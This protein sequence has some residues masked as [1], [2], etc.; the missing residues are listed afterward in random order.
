MQKGQALQEVWSTGLLVNGVEITKMA[1]MKTLTLGR[2]YV[3]H[4]YMWVVPG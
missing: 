3:I 2:N 1:E 4:K